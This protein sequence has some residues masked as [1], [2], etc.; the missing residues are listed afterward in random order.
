MAVPVAFDDGAVGAAA[1]S[2]EEPVIVSVSPPPGPLTRLTSITVVFNEPVT[3]V[4]A[5]DLRVNDI[6]A[7]GLAGSGDTY[8]FMFPQPAM[9]IIQISWDMNCGITDLGAPP[10]QFNPTGVTARWMYE[11]YDPTPPVVA[12][13]N[14]PAGQDVRQLRQIEVV[15]NKAVAGVDAADLMINGRPA[16]SVSGTAAGPYVF[17][18]DVQPAGLATVTWAANHGITDCTP[19]G[20]LFEGGSWSYHVDP[21]RPVPSVM[22]NEIMAENATGL[23]DEDGD[24][25]D[26]IELYNGWT[27]DV[28]L[29]GWSLSDDPQDPGK[30]L[31]P[32]VTLGAGKFMVVFASGKDRK[33]TTSG[34]RLHTNFKLGINGEY[35]GLFMP[36]SPRFAVSEL[37]PRF[38]EQR[39]DVSYGRDGAGEWK[40]YARGSPGLANG[41]SAISNAVSP[42]HFSVR[43]GFYAKPFKL[44]LATETPGAQIIFTMDGSIPSLTNGVV[45]TNPMTISSTR[46]VR[47][48][49]FRTNWLPS[50]VETHTYLYG[51]PPARRVLPALSI[52]TAS[53]NL[54][55]PKGI[56]EYNPR[57][58]IYHG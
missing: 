32:N 12:V 21:A 9:G 6:P 48:A 19:A 42:V 36:E 1:A 31:F 50:R 5:R 37:A 39:I 28:A 34:G 13:L 54:Y 24:A 40:Y 35:L 7:T 22:I 58:T 47:A 45:Y 3:G 4:D 46:I 14:P 26:W 55:G 8:T 15:F 11:L 2:G 43:R 38:P 52:V 29:A 57:N 25:E 18:F 27:N 53:N 23:K 20:S 33:P 56:M 44:S 10:N 30:W 49:A 41:T 16:N 17:L 51:L